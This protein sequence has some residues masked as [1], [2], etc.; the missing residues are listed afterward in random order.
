MHSKTKTLKMK[1]LALIIVSLF[2]AE[3][4]MS[5]IQYTSNNLRSNTDFVQNLSGPRIGFTVITDGKLTETLDE[6]FGVTTNVISQFGYQF[7]K[8]IM[9]DENVAGLVEGIVFIGGIEQGMFLPSVSGLFGAR[10]ASGTEFAIGPNLSLSGA[11]LVVGFGKTLHAGN[12][13][14]P[15]NIAWVPSVT[16]RETDY[17]E[18]YDS[19]TQMWINEDITSNRS[20]GHR[21]TLTVGF[22]FLK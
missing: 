18:Y 17:N 9:G 14:I 1:K 2:I 21:I 5:Q 4:G 16:R 13:N 20:T 15:I 22:N 6:E 19:E 10:F 11:G 3:Q 12:I 7:E 8:Q